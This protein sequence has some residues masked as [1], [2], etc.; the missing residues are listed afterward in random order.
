MSMREEVQ[1]SCRTDLLSVSSDFMCVAVRASPLVAAKPGAGLASG[2]A[3][4]PEAP[5]AWPR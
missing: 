4:S 1:D 2:W 3:T 5:C